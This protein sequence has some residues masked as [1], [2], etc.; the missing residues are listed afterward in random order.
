[1]AKARIYPEIDLPRIKNPIRLYA[2]PVLGGVVKGFMLIPVFVWTTILGIAYFFVTII[3]SFIVLFTGKY[4]SV[5]YELTAL[6]IL[7]STKVA[8]F[9]AG[10]SNIYPGFTGETKDFK[11]DIPYPKNPS[12]FFAFPV[13]G[14]IARLVMLIP[15]LIYAYVIQYAGNL[16]TYA[17]SFVV[18]SKGKYPE[19][20]YELARDSVRI[21]QATAFYMAGL[22]DVYPSWWISMNHKTIKIILIVLGTLWVLLN[23]QSRSQNN[24]YQQQYNNQYYYP[25]SVPSVN[26]S[27]Y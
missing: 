11:M 21:S 10:L 4:W 20:F 22:E 13:I 5:A 12:R 9:W 27:T 18:L 19:S 26:P 7:I 6:I 15:F 1:M 24:R 2:F 14:G 3:N 17:A 23:F 25:T 8:F 16:G